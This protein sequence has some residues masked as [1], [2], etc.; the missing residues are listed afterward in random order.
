[1]PADAAVAE[2]SMADSPTGAVLI[3][4]EVGLE[5]KQLVLLVEFDFIYVQAE[6]VPVP[7]SPNVT[8]SPTTDSITITGRVPT[9]S[10]SSLPATLVPS[11]AALTITG[12]APTVSTTSS[13]HVGAYYPEYA[14]ATVPHADIPWD[15]LTDLFYF[16]M[17]FRSHYSSSVNTTTDVFTSLGHPFTENQPIQLK[18]INGAATPSHAGGSLAYDTNYFA[19]DVVAGQTFKLSLTNGGAAINFT[20]TGVSNGRAWKAPTAYINRYEFTP[21][22]TPAAVQSLLAERN[23][24]NPACKVHLVIGRDHNH[25]E[26]IDAMDYNGGNGLNELVAN[27]R[28]IFDEGFDGLSTDIE[29]F[30][31]TG[32]QGLGD[33]GQYIYDFHEALHAEFPG[34]PLVWYIGR[35]GPAV[36]VENL[37]KL[38]LDNNFVTGFHFSGYAMLFPGF[39]GSQVRPHNSLHHN[40]S[41]FGEP[42]GNAAVGQIEGVAQF[43]SVGIPIGMIWL[44]DQAG[45]IPW[46]GGSMTGPAG[47][48]GHGARFPGDTWASGGTAPTTPNEITY[49]NRSSL[50]LTATDVDDL[51]VAFYGYK[52]DASPANELFWASL[53]PTTAATKRA[54]WRSQGAAGMF[55]WQLGGDDPTFPLIEAMR[56]P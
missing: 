14:S 9:V 54:Y 23:S 34:V 35:S 53:D 12:R 2:T 47:S 40:Q 48:V 8:V 24:Q 21:S 6:S 5:T 16:G 10:A 50:A 49:R 26:L 25:Q 33:G 4:P 30:N 28:S 15:K 7:P 29:G 13:W 37:A 1:V 18:N 20:G 17:T 51:A 45:G 3:I 38:M 56:L 31:V 41:D 39:S 22:T 55:L 11:T 43:T 44:G 36:T 32:S 52:T 19:R 46:T 42:T 27:I